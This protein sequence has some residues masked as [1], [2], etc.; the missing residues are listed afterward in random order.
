MS[1]AE[2]YQRGANDFRAGK[3]FD[4]AETVGWEHGF[5][6]AITIQPAEEAA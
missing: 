5:G 3:P 6:D 4:P 2:D 1:Y